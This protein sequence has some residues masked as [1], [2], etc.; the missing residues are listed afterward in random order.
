M[1]RESCATPSR[2]TSAIETPSPNPYLRIREALRS[3]L[4]RP[5]K[6][7]GMATIRM[8][9]R[10]ER[11]EFADFLDTLTPQQW[12]V[13]SLC[14]G[15]TVQ[16]VVT[17][18]IAYLDQTRRHLFFEMLRHRWNVDR[19]NASALDRSA[20]QPPGQTVAQMRRGAEP[21]GAGALYSGRVALIECLIHHQDIRRPLGCFR[22]V[23]H[24]RLRV[25]LN[26]ARMSPVIG[27]ARR[28]R[29][30]R[31]VAT[32]MDW[33]AGRGP[34]VRGTGE[35]LLLAMT[36]RFETVAGELAGPGAAY[37]HS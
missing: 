37:L 9:A 16:D 28:T 24:D 5:V 18:T 36:G 22:A 30:V 25:S 31:L 19:L 33:A 2:R 13:P 1:A 8:L 34:D 20:T 29:G 12:D 35:A 10:Q 32:D 6:L 27:G 26:F 15:W 14:E 7:S 21:S 11:A 3:A 4:S 23:P 17:H